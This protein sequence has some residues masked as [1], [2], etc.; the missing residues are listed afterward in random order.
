MFYGLSIGFLGSNPTTQIF[1]QV[2]MSMA[3]VIYAQQQMPYTERIDNMF[4]IGNELTILSVMT[5]SVRYADRAPSPETA[6]NW[7]FF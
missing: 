3:W 7:G 6:S 1:V 2:A 4:E 5:T